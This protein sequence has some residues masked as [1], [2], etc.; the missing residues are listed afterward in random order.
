MTN[1]NLTPIRTLIL[2]GTLGCGLTLSPLFAATKRVPDSHVAGKVAYIP[3]RRLTCS[4]RHVTNF[5]PNKEQTAAELHYDAVQLLTLVLPSI[6]VRTKAPPEPQ[7]EPE[8]VDART[9]IIL[10]PGH[11]APSKRGRFDRVI[12][13]WPDRTELSAIISGDLLNV[14][15]I[16]N[17]DPANKTANFFMTRATELTRFQANHVYQGQ[18]KVLIG[19][20]ATDQPLA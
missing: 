15:V 13:Y 4:V 5:D 19:A 8:P 9:R 17:Y 14:I 20:S 10:D 7:D 3:E 6:A 1:A 11:I 16:N 12:D 18:C 2:A